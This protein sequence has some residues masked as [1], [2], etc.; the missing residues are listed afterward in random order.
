MNGPEPANSLGKPVT[1]SSH[2][3]SNIVTYLAMAIIALAAAIAARLHLAL[4]PHL[5]IAFGITLFCVLVSTH[6]LIK[7]QTRSTGS[8]GKS[9][10]TRKKS[11]QS[12]AM[13]AASA[14][15]DRSD[16]LAERIDEL[17][18]EKRPPTDDL[19][20]M[21]A[22]GGRPAGDTAP[23]PSLN[24]EPASN[25]APAAGERATAELSD[26]LA[27][28]LQTAP[29]NPQTKSAPDVEPRQVATPPQGELPPAPNF[30]ASPAAHPTPSRHGGSFAPKDPILSQPIEDLGPPD[31]TARVP[32]TPAPDQA[33]ADPALPPAKPNIE[34]ILKRMAAQINAGRPPAATTPNPNAPAKG[35]ASGHTAA[36][37]S[38]STTVDQPIDH[39]TSEAVDA[40]REAAKAMSAKIDGPTP[41][42]DDKANS[43]PIQNRLAEIAEAVSRNQLDIYLD[44]IIAFADGRPRHFEVTVFA[45]TASGEAIPPEDFRDTTRGSGL[46]PLLDASRLRHSSAIADRLAGRLQNSSVFSA[47]DGESLHSKRFFADINRERDN[48]HLRATQLILSFQQADVRAFAPGHF[49][50]LKILRDMGFRFAME[51]ITD[52]DMNFEAIA[53]IGFDFVK[54]DADV[55]LNGMRIG[56]TTLSAREVCRHLEHVGLTVIIG[57]ISSESQRSEITNTGVTFGQGRVFGPPA[58]VLKAKTGSGAERAA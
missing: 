30:A 16:A 26:R 13:P 50:S 4:A 15:W 35:P 47:L 5:T 14:Q 8:I 10:R 36:P 3:L 9:R 31:A 39:S 38:P 40:L 6:L 37:A 48:G 49:Q 24:L 21:Y 56:A 41:S 32:T 55:Y 44:P 58:A 28:A 12:K 1:V 11:E 29:N 33:V 25:S 34:T 43:P 18:I 20:G 42:K 52:L 53:A 51:G 22:P 2:R 17:I 46:M 27:E 57:A 54:L 23:M 7:S 45:K 19:A